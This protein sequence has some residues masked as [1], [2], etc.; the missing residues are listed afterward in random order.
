[1]KKDM[2]GLKK[3]IEVLTNSWK[4]A[5]ADY[6][7]LEKRYQKEKTDF[8]QFATAN[9]ILKLLTVLDHLERI[10]TYLRDDGLDLALKEFKKVLISEGLD[11]IEVLGR[12]FDPKEMEACG[13]AEG[14]EEKVVETV[15]RGYRLKGSVI[16]PA[17]VK[18][19]Q[20]KK[21]ETET[22]SIKD[23]IKGGI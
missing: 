19:G 14:E 11:E 4:R 2:K 12:K 9:L 22:S 18:V 1:M 15:A 7:N 21:I 5:L 13:W 3:E 16:R 10:Q 23:T 17:K 6:Q 20:M 8:I